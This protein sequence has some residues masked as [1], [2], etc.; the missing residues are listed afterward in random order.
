MKPL[1]QLSFAERVAL[2]ESFTRHVLAQTSALNYPILVATD[3]PEYDFARHSSN[4]TAVFQQ[5][6]SSF[7]EKLAHALHAAFA[8]GYEEVVCVGND[9]L[10]LSTNDLRT[11]FAQ[12]AQ[13][14]LVLGA[15]S[16]GGV[17]LIALR[18]ESLSAVLRI[19]QECHWQT[20]I[21]RD[22]LLASACRNDIATG[23][24]AQHNDIDTAVELAHACQSLIA[25]VFLRRF[26]SLLLLLRLQPLVE[27]SFVPRIRNCDP[28]RFQK[29][30]PAFLHE[31]IFLLP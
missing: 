1:A 20:A 18:R 12:L 6:G 11:A 21:V 26:V 2:Y 30:P 29:A 31:S 24:L 3:K 4:I 10:E 23:V 19:M 28:L 27:L 7:G 8:Q 14:E 25:L 16:D 22:E 5:H 15:A 13:R 9:C 17:Y